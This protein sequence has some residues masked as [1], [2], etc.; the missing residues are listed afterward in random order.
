M[1][2]DMSS[3]KAHQTCAAAPAC[4]DSLTLTDKGA[5]DAFCFPP[6]FFSEKALKLTDKELT[7]LKQDMFKQSQARAYAV[8]LRY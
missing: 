2:V 6:F 5:D 1:C 3:H 8:Y 7:A 4:A